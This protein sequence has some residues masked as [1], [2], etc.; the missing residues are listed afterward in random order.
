MLDNL[1]RMDKIL[2]TR[3]LPRLNQEIENLNKP[4]NDKD[5]ELFI[6]KP[7]KEKLDLMAS[8]M[9]S[10]RHLK[11]SNPSQTFPKLQRRVHLLTC[12]LRAALPL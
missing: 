2:E 11:V 4:K 7:N 3:N 12:S 6:Q 1:Y 9:N 5:I 10:P 8:L